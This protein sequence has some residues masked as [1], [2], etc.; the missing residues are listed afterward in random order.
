ML[1]RQFSARAMKNLDLPGTL[2]SSVTDP[3]NLEDLEHSLPSVSVTSSGKPQ[4]LASNRSMDAVKMKRN[5]EGDC[6]PHSTDDVRID[7]HNATKSSSAKDHGDILPFSS[8]DAKMDVKSIDGTTVTKE[9]GDCLPFSSECVR[10]DGKELDLDDSSSRKCSTRRCGMCTVI[11]LMIIALG[12]GLGLGLSKKGRDVAA[13]TET[14]AS[15]YLP[16]FPG[17][18]EDTAG[19][20]SDPSFENRGTITLTS[21]AFEYGEPIPIRYTVDAGDVSPPLDWSSVPAGT[22]DIVIVCEDVDFP[23]PDHPASKPFVHWFAYSVDSEMSNIPENVP[24]EKRLSEPLH[25]TDPASGEKYLVYL[26]QGITSYGVS[27][28]NAGSSDAR[29]YGWGYHGPDPPK[30]HPPH[31]YYFRIL[32]LDGKVKDHISD[33]AVE[34]DMQKVKNLIDGDDPELNVLGFGVLMGTYQKA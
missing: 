13:A 33:S 10:T 30:G 25:G 20:R 26:R 24:K 8:E 4:R 14:W 15:K 9:D 2:R 11:L 16:G 1:S 23:H 6:L 21:P 17:S 29:I 32:A 34:D 27:V 5:D 12:V 18:K 31:R 7:M 28:E 3:D 22:K 19:K